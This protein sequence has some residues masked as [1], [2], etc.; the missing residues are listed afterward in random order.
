M[1]EIAVP[2]DAKAGA[3]ELNLAEVHADRRNADLVLSGDDEVLHLEFQRRADPTMADRMLIYR[4]LLRVEPAC[5]GKRI[6][7][8]VIVLGEGTSPSRIDE[9]PNLVFAFETHYARDLDPAKAI[10]DPLTA[11]WAMLAG[12]REGKERETRLATILRAATSVESKSLARDLTMTTLAFAAIVMK[13]ED[14]ERALREAGMS[15]DSSN[16]LVW[17][18]ELHA[19]GRAEGVRDSAAK[20]LVHRGIDEG[21]ARLIAEVL[22]GQDAD[23]ATER[24]AFDELGG[25][26][27]LVADK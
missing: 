5:S 1:F 17:A 26:T 10:A 16:D 13:R 21:K 12:A 20:L 22:I 27:A 18:D 3:T 14:V 8:H 24:A 4:S 11:P 2:V 6:E 23:T 9:P 7:Q 15:T 19:E 25:L